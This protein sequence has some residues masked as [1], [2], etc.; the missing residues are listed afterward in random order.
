[1]IS[2]DSAI[3]HDPRAA[4]V[5]AVMYELGQRAGSLQSDQD[6]YEAVAD[7]IARILDVDRLSIGLI[8][9][10]ADDAKTMIPVFARGAPIEDTVSSGRP[11]PLVLQVLTMKRAVLYHRGDACNNPEL[12]SGCVRTGWAQRAISPVTIGDQHVGVLEIDSTD[13]HR[14]AENDL[15]IV[16]SFGNM[17]GLMLSAWKL[18]AQRRKQ[19]MHD[20]LVRDVA[21][22]MTCRRE[23]KEVLRQL[24]E[25]IGR[26]VDCDVLILRSLDNGWVGEEPFVHDPSRLR[27]RRSLL[28][29]IK[30]IQPPVQSPLRNAGSLPGDSSGSTHDLADLVSRIDEMLESADIDRSVISSL[31]PDAGGPLVLVALRSNH[32]GREFSDEDRATIEYIMRYMSPALINARLNDDLA[33]VLGEREAVHRMATAVGSGRNTPDRI[34]IACRTAQLLFACDYV[35]LID[36]STQP[37]TVRFA[38]GSTSTEP[39]TLSRAGTITAVRRSGDVRIIN[40]FPNDPPLKLAWY[41]LHVAE[42]LRASLTYRLQWSGKT[43]GSLILGFRKPRRFSESDLRFAESMAHAIVAGLGPELHLTDTK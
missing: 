40:D 1:M 15:W 31:C 38:V 11:N 3:R 25:Q 30:S 19:A 21:P 22:L 4:A 37:P 34:G 6:I 16:E 20:A 8:E 29:R 39:F 7:G 32:G 33:R 23:P 41:P 24:A 18:T 12:A 28:D 5:S 43:F 2:L 17:L 14:L 10:A 9:D 26:S 13:Q 42:G 36:W 27:E 35:A